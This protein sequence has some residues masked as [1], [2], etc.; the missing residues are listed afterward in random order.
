MTLEEVRQDL[1]QWAESELVELWNDYCEA[2]GMDS[3]IIYY[4]DEEFLDTMFA[5]PAEA[6]RASFFGD[7]NW[8]DT[9]VVFNGYG[10][11][12]SYYDPLEAMDL[13]ALA[14][15]YYENNNE[16]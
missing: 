6:V 12:Q 13:D 3:D 11:L 5:S 15:W 1:E 10:N 2:T 8:G 4:N 16:E 9:Y 7:Y 14:E